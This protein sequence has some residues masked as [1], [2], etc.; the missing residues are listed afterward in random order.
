MVVLR[1]GDIRVVKNGT[2]L[3]QPFLSHP[4]RRLERAARASSRACCRWRSRPTT[5]PAGASTSSWSAT[6]PTPGA[7]PHGP[8]EIREYR[9]SAANPDVA[10]PATQRDGARDP[11]H[12]ST[13]TTTAAR[14]SSGPTAC[15]TRRSATAGAGR[16]ATTTPRTPNSQL[17]KL[18]RLDPRS[19]GAAPSA[20]RHEPFAGG[21]RAIRSSTPTACATRSASPSIA[22]PGDL[23]IGDV[24]RGRRPRRSTSCPA[25]AAGSARTSA[26]TPARAGRCRSTSVEPVHLDHDGPSTPIPTR[27][28]A[29]R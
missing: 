12:R 25:P 28:A 10:D 27:R 13:P 2:T 23:T 26:G 22:R 4:R 6:T 7:A 18:L 14:C 11:A 17:G 21:G 24:G 3:A 20:C 19:S 16:R 29:P 5:G 15:S 9:R 8:I 1:D